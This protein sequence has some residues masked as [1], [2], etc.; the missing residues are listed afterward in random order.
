M[1]KILKAPP[2]YKDRYDSMFRTVEENLL[3][4]DYIF[5]QQKIKIAEA[6][7]GIFFF[8]H[9]FFRNLILNRKNILESRW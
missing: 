9:R 2:R 5:Q 4:K 6:Y 3:F 7:F 1:L 8:N